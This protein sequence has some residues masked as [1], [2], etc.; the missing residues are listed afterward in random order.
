MRKLLVVLFVFAV[1][2][3]SAP[4]FQETVISLETLPKLGAVLADL[5][6]A[7]TGTLVS[8]SQTY[9]S[10]KTVVDGVEYTLG[11]DDEHRVRYVATTDASFRI[12][13]LKMG[14]S[15][16]AVMRAAPGATVRMENGWGSYVELPS[17]WRA[18]LDD[19]TECCPNLGTAPLKPTARVTMF[20]LRD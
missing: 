5:P 13:G 10:Y 15:M 3:V 8:P 6:E 4:R 14:D 18:F 2:C 9:K 1:G 12:D 7:T 11:V 19:G 17:G 20:F 16:D